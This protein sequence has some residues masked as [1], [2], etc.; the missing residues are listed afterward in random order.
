MTVAENFDLPV[1]YDIRTI[2]QVRHKM[3]HAL[4]ENIEYR[5]SMGLNNLIIHLRKGE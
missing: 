3:I 1:F 2:E 5:R 4:A